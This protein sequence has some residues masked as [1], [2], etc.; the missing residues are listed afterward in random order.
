M[1]VGD[2]THSGKER[3]LQLREFLRA[4]ITAEARKRLKAL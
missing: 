2:T 4:P 3:L 1:D